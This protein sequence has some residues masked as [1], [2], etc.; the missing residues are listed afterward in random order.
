[1]LVVAVVPLPLTLIAVAEA[2]FLTT[3]TALRVSAWGGVAI[4]FAAGS[5]VARQATDS[6]TW[7]ILGGLL[8]SSLGAAIILLEAFFAH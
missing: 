7:M 1:M 4:L 8:N 6:M 3:T 5:T 2:G